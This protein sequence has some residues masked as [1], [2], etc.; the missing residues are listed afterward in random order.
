[1][2]DRLLESCTKEFERQVADIFAD[3]RNQPIV[4]CEIPI[5]GRLR[6]VGFSPHAPRQQTYFLEQLAVKALLAREWFKLFEAPPWATPLP[7][8]ED[9]IVACFNPGERWAACGQRRSN[10]M[11]DYGWHLRALDW[12]WGNATPFEVFC[13]GKL[14]G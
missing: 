10:L 7:L 3:L 6:G 14:R 13:A 11:G 2:D 9:D 8:T 12:E 5:I 4:G 1:M